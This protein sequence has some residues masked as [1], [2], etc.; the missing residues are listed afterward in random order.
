MFIAVNKLQVPAEHQQH[1]L[2]AFE[3]AMPSMKRFKGFLGFELWTGE[4]NTILGV[5]RWE[6]KEAMEEY[7]KNDLFR[8]H[9]GSASDEQTQPTASYSASILV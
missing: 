7:L 4:D 6:S 5:S 8:Q 1:L 2:Q 9:H 3:K